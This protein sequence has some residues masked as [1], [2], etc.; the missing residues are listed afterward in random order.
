VGEGGWWWK[1]ELTFGLG[2]SWSTKGR[3]E[4]LDD[5]E[6]HASLE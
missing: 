3:G 2:E 1:K 4:S 6:V 5:L